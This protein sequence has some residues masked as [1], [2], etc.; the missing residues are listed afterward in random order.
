VSHDLRHATIDT[1]KP[2]LQLLN[3]SLASSIFLKIGYRG[4]F[5]CCSFDTALIEA[6]RNKSSGQA[7]RFRPE[8]LF[9]ATSG[10]YSRLAFRTSG[11]PPLLHAAVA[12]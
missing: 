11:L 7:T 1:I 3:L 9:M 5:R 2:N 4:T 8:H 10:Y 12:C 6:I